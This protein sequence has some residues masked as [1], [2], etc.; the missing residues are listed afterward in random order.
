MLF[1]LYIFSIFKILGIYE[2]DRE[3]VSED[4]ICRKPDVAQRKCQVHVH[5]PS[6]P[7]Q[8]SKLLWSVRWLS[9]TT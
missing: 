4:L 1:I 9:P 3:P 2:Q 5:T 7:H 8:L 6:P